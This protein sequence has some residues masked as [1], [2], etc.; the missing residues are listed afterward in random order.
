MLAT[1]KIRGVPGKSGILPDR[2]LFCKAMMVVMERRPEMDAGM[3]PWRPLKE[4][5]SK[6]S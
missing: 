4:R 2:E 5:F 3:D 6:R 1:L